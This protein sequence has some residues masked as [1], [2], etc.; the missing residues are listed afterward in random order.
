MDKNMN[1]NMNNNENMNENM[2]NV[3]IE[4]TNENMNENIDNDMNKNVNN[5]EICTFIY[6]VNK[7]DNFTLSR[8]LSLYLAIQKISNNCKKYNKDF[9]K[10][11]LSPIP[12][13]KYIDSVSKIIEEDLKNNKKFISI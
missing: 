2:N 9:N 11:E 13:K 3:V 10:L 6:D 1:D 5:E 12:I 7:M 4:N 8:W